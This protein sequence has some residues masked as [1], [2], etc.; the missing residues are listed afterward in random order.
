MKKTLKINVTQEDIDRGE[1]SRPSGCPIAIALRRLIPGVIVGT[2]GIYDASYDKLTR[3][4]PRR[5]AEFIRR[6]DLGQSVK[7][8]RFQVTLK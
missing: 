7:P 1:P 8:F 6:F 5:A 4:T 2:I 3:G